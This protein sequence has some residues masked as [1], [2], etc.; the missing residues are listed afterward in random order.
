MKRPLLYCIPIVHNEADLGT[1]APDARRAMGGDAE[2]AWARKQAAIAEFWKGVAAWCGRLPRN[3]TTYRLYQDG[4]PVCGR[5]RAIVDELAAQGSENHRVLLTLIGRGA[6]LEGT[7][8]A[9]LLIEE[10]KLA[11]A[12]LRGGG[13]QPSHTTPPSVE[14]GHDV[15]ARSAELLR[16]RDTFIAEQI[17]RT[18]HSG[19]TAILFIGYLH[20]VLTKLPGTID[21]QKVSRLA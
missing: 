15:R 12:T 18:L 17:T 11:Q 4:L 8:S 5:E 16:Q 19:E 2:R 10:Y 9:D 21:V 6:R 3:L 14:P 7:E 20:D 1:L 13:D